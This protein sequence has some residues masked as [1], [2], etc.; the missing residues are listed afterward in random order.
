MPDPVALC[1]GGAI[2][3]FHLCRARGVE[4]WRRDVCR[5]VDPHRMG[6]PVGPAV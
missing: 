6:R 5:C 2:G 3:S 1:A 4:C